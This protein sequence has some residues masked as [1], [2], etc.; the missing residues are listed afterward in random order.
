MANGIT[1]VAL[2]GLLTLVAS[3]YVL[4]EVCGL[5]FAMRI[6]REFSASG[7]DVSRFMT[8]FMLLLSALWGYVLWDL[9]SRM[10][11]KI[12]RELARRAH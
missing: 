5:E 10:M 9:V 1:P 7:P 12:T 6:S 4:F 8:M 2:C 3:Y 11:E